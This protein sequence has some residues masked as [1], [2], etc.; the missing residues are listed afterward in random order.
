MGL[1]SR[2]EEGK[3][4]EEQTKGKRGFLAPVRKRVPQGGGLV[5]KEGGGQKGEGGKKRQNVDGLRKRG[6][7]RIGKRHTRSLSEGGLVRLA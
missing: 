7:R 5:F 1:S 4:Q 2:T 3:R 6:T